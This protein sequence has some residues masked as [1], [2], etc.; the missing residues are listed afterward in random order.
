M[1]RASNPF[2]A[3]TVLAML[4]VGAVAFLLLLYAIGQGWD[5][6]SD[7]DGG[8]H[9]ASNGLNGFA[10]MVSLLEE[11]GYDVEVSRSRG[12]LDTYGLLVLTPQLFSDGE[13][14]ADV[15]ADRQFND[16]GPT[17]V[18][19]PKWFAF[20]VPDGADVDAQD[21]WVL[22][23]QAGS[24]GWFAELDYGE[25]GELAI[26]ETKGWNGLGMTGGL[27]DSERAQALTSQPDEEMRAR[28]LDS[29]GDIL[30]ADLPSESAIAEYDYAPYPVTFVFEPDLIN[31]YGLADEDRARLAYSLIEVATEGDRSMPVVFDLTLAG[32]G[33]SDNLLTLAFS[34]PFLAATLC[35]LLAALVIAWRAFRRF[36]PPIAEAPAMTQGKRQLAYNGASLVER[37]KRFHLLSAPYASLMSKR[38]GDALGIRETNPEARAQ[39]ID[40]ALQ[41]RGIEGPGFIQRANDLR[42]ASGP[43]DIIRAA[44]ALKSIERTLKR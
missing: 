7:R 10:G 14:L 36:G 22:L 38:I 33:S 19:M 8:S 30:V 9:A 1:S 35:L 11:T 34:P 23:M 12:S 5:G 15:I 26:G 3:G 21:G 37:V 4:A 28:V 17:L 24:P 13:D 41:R 31:N 40:Q 25:G 42:D 32:L 27:P 39:A 18:I 16:Y 20:N 2:R 44:G 6:S 43:R 29:E